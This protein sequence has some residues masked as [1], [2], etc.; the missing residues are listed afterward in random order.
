M[1]IINRYVLKEHIGP[2]VFALSALTSLLLL[3]VIAR[4]FGDLVGKGLSWQVITEFFLLSFPYVIAMTLPMAVLVAVLY[5]FSRLASEN[6]V[7]ALKAGGISTRSLLW[8]ALIAS[9]LLAIFMLWFNDQVLPRANHQLATLQIAI[10]RTKP[11]FALK[12]QVINTI[13]ESQLYLSAGYIAEDQSGRLHD[14]QIYDVSDP[15]RRKTIYA[16]SGTLAFASNKRDLDLHLYSGVMITVPNDKSGQVNRIYYQQNQLKVRDVGGS[17][18]PLSADTTSKSDREMSICE[19]QKQYEIAHVRVTSAKTDSLMAV[20]RS[21]GDQHKNMT[22]APKPIAPTKA[23]GIGA[24]YCT[25]VT[26]YFN[27]KYLEHY[28][29]YFHVKTAHAAEVPRSI[30]QDTTKRDTTKQDTTKQDT[31]KRRPLKPVVPA[32]VPQHPDSVFV[33]LDGRY[34]KVPWNKFPPGS[35]FPD[36][37]SVPLTSDTSRPPDRPIVPNSAAPAAAIIDTSAA[38]RVATP[39]VTPVPAPTTATPEHVQGVPSE[40]LDAHIRLDEARHSSNRYGVEI[41]KK[42][43]L[44]AACIVFVVV[45][46]PIALRFPRGGVGLVIGVSFAVFGV[47]YVGLIGGEAL[48]NKNIISPFWAMWADNIIFLLIG[49]LLVTRMGSEGVTSRGGNIGEMLDRIRAWFVR[50]ERRPGHRPGVIRIPGAVRR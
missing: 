46:A 42:F 48:A 4:R 25:M 33:L 16:D 20:W 35:R 10:F 22:S 41:Q 24:L 14:V 44:A 45:G 17:F 28:L 47:Y 38:A 7:T 1:K 23:G 40:V 34:V 26:K 19:M 32:V 37:T 39:V 5:A 13:K 43:S 15:S 11:T 21:A 3:Q 12:P 31:T 9:T 18:D 8:P 50:A 29:K 36:G 49:A 30:H 2:F 6:E 27:R